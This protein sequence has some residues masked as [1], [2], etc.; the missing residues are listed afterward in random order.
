MA[1]QFSTGT[2]NAALDAIEAHIG[3]APTLT[4][5]TGAV[6]ANCAAA[7]AGT[8]LA[9]LVLPSDWMAPAANGIK[10]LSGTWQDVAAD[11]TGVACHFSLDQGATCHDQGLVAMAWA[12]SVSVIVGEHRM[13][14][15]NLYRCS[16]AGATASSGGPT[17]TGGSITDG[18]AVWA[19]VQVGSDLTLDN[20]SLA[21]GQQVN[22]TG[23]TITAGGA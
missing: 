9:T 1:H 8:V 18:T 10:G 5:R 11:A 13:N 22:I 16:T 2:R 7:R 15:G 19:Y 14:G 4:L 6:P 12:A 17:G 21:T 20:T 3:T 23:F